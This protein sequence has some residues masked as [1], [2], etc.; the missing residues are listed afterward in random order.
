MFLAPQ[1]LDMINI[2]HLLNDVSQSMVTGLLHFPVTIIAELDCTSVK[3]QS[4]CVM[5]QRSLFSNKLNG[6]LLNHSVERDHYEQIK[7]KIRCSFENE[8]L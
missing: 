6:R 4:K 7:I 3:A 1:S 8:Q 2:Y 5:L